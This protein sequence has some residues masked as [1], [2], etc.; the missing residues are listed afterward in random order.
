MMPESRIPP[1]ALLVLLIACLYIYGIILDPAQ[2]FAGMDFFNLNLPRVMISQQALSS[3]HVPL[4]NW[5]E[6]G[7][8]PLLAAMQGAVFYPPTWLA[9]ALPLPFGLQLFIFLHLYAAAVGCFLLARRLLG[10]EVWCSILAGIA[11]AGSGFYIGRIEQFQI[12]AVNCLL[13]WLVLAGARAVAPDGHCRWLAL[14]WAFCLLAGHP[15][16]A[17]F[18]LLAMLAFCAG[19]ATA[20]L[21]PVTRRAWFRLA[22]GVAL[23]SA[24]AAVQLLP[25][26]ELGQLSERIW[27]Y[28]DA[29][30][31]Q[32]AWRDLPALLIPRYYQMVSGEP[33]RVFGHTELG[34]YAGLLALPLVAAG[35]VLLRTM[36]VTRRRWFLVAL[37][38]WLG[39]MVFALGSHTYLAT[40]TYKFAP[41]FRQSRGAGR[42]LNIAALILALLV[43]SGAS[44]L[45]F[46]LASAPRKAAL[47]GYALCALFCVDLAA[48]NFRELSSV[49]VPT[50]VL[51][52][53]PF[54][55][56]SCPSRLYRFMS[57]DSDLYLNNTAQAVAERIIRVQPNVSSTYGVAVLDGYEEGLLPLRARADLF[58]RFNRNLRWDDPDAAL[59]AFMGSSQMLTEFPLP[60]GGHWHLTQGPALRPSVVPSVTDGPA[61]YSLYESAY[62]PGALALDLDK[63]LSASAQPAFLAACA[64]AFPLEISARSPT[65]SDWQNTPFA[66]ITPEAFDAGALPGVTLGWNRISIPV[67]EGTT[68]ILA[69]FTPYPGWTTDDNFLPKEQL[70]TLCSLF[71]KVELPLG[72]SK[73]S[74]IN[75]TFRPYSYRL[76][77]FISL[78][79]LL[80]LTYMIGF[81]LR[82]K[83]QEY[84]K[85]E[86]IREQ[87][88]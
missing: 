30:Q 17:I 78:S 19:A 4:W 50:S 53:K 20:G 18:N 26:Y 71:W 24:L 68:N 45:V 81:R 74:H 31:P 73:T 33:G 6:W 61:E 25:T 34:L 3:G 41:F 28:A 56:P 21:V 86:S 51:R 35:L 60:T 2:T 11:F 13:P 54:A 16:Y 76:G 77:L 48:N 5:Y 12:V 42:S 27:P 22:G 40:V 66:S 38:V 88:L 36:P 84:H 58:R 46:R 49:L 44:A 10:L 29:T 72:A 70:K 37:A 39:A 57:A 63:L 32:L 80:V 67:N 23:G 47:A 59:L 69:L 7:G 15:Q 14:C 87:A 65:S 55:T 52:F 9:M 75:L 85:N 8:A 1:I 83:Q 43:A 62:A 64:S 79:S 82:I